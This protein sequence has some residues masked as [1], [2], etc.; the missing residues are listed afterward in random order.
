MKSIKTRL[1]IYFGVLLIVVCAAFGISANLKASEAVMD[2]GEH[3]LETAAQEASMLIRSFLDQKIILMEA[4][5]AQKIVTDDVP[6]EEKVATLQPEAER[7]GYETFAITDLSGNALRLKGDP[8]NVSDRDYF[9]LAARGKS[10]KSTNKPS[11]IVAVP[12]MRD[13]SVKGVLTQYNP[14]E[15]AKDKPELKA[16]ADIMANKMLKGETGVARYQFEDSRR[17][18]A[19]EPIEGTEWSVAVA[20]QESEMY[21]HVKELN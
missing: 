18:M 1:T 21:E 10:S 8:V 4:I 15:D 7:N 5:A 11:V 3:T 2:E 14:V 17:I 16:L 19:Y 9:K 13:G 12:I 20:I 6:W